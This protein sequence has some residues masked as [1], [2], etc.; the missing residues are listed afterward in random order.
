[1][2]KDWNS[3]IQNSPLLKMTLRPKHIF[4][5]VVIN[6]L[7]SHVL[8]NIH[9][10]LFLH[11]VNATQ[12]QVNP[13]QPFSFQ[14]SKIIFDLIGIARHRTFYALLSLQISNSKLV[15]NCS[16]NALT[17]SQNF[18]VVWNVFHTLRFKTQFNV[19]IFSS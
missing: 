14:F 12:K 19:R 16:W 10:S 1:M 15:Q 2:T 13:L 11:S 8:N 5:N 17:F 7:I 3:L 18:T 6:N 4:A 9:P